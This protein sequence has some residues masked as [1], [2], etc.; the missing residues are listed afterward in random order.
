[1]PKAK[2]YLQ[3]KDVAE[4]IGVSLNTVCTWGRNGKIQEHRHPINNYRLFKRSDSK[5]NLRR[6]ERSAASG[7]RKP[8]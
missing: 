5:Q 4:F 1:M 6:I 8:R 2:V 7:G 3:I